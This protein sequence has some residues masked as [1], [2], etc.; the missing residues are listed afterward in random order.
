MNSEA[1]C[2]RGI[3]LGATGIT[4]HAWARCPWVL[5]EDR[6][7]TLVFIF[8]FWVMPDIHRVIN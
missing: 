5:D 4:N 3:I 6:G 1:G 7:A 2:T 8:L